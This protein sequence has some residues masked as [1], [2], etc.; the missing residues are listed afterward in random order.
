ML[1]YTLHL[2]G[3]G[4]K[5]YIDYILKRAK[6]PIDLDIIYERYELLKKKEDG[7]FVMT[8]LERKDIKNLVEEEVS[9]LDYYETNDHRYTLLGKSNYRKGRLQINK[10]GEGILHSST[11][12]TDKDGNLVIRNE[13]FTISSADCNGAID[14]DL[15]LIEISHA[16][17]KP[18]VERILER[19]IGNVFGEITRLG[20]H[21]FLT[22]IDPKQKNLTIALEG[23]Y[24]EGTLVLASLEEKSYH[25]YVGKVL[26]EFR[27]KDDP[28]A[29]SLT[30]AVK[31]GMPIGFSEESMRQLEEIPTIVSLKDKEGRYD[32]TNWDIFTIDGVDTKD[33]DDAISFTNVSLPDGHSL[34]GVHIADTPHYVPTN[35]P[36][37]KDAFRKGTSY[38]FGGSVNPQYPR[39]I[40]NGICSL[41]D[42]VERL[43][44]SILMEYDE[45]GNIVRRSLV[46]GV[47]RS[48]I[49]MNY[50]KVN[51]ILKDGVVDSEYA[52]YEKTLLQ[53]AKLAA[54][55]RKKRK[56]MGAISFSRGEPYFHYDDKGDAYDIVFKKQDLSEHLIEEFMLA[57]NHN[58]GAIME[59]AGLPTVYRVHG[60]PNR[61]KLADLLR[62]LDCMN[63]PFDYSAEEICQNKAYMQALSKHISEKGGMLQNML[64]TRLICCMAHAAYCSEN[65]GH[66]GTGF[67]VYVHFTSPI[68]RLADDT[69]SRVLDECYFEKDE[70][71]KNKAIRKWKS[72]VEI[73]SVQASKMERISEEVEKNVFLRDSAIFFSNHLEEEFEGTVIS[74]SKSGL[75]I[76]LDNLLEGRIPTYSLPGNYVYNPKTFTLLSLDDFDSY[77]MG[78]RLKVRVKSTDF[79][80]KTVH[81]SVLGK[82]YEN[83]IEDYTDSNEVLKN[84]KIVKRNNR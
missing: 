44:K 82:I 16:G 30:E 21:Y 13:M 51:A 7:N 75:T 70:E 52:P 46:R 56:N 76:Q 33:K 79:E 61:E 15:V 20:N 60:T 49:G 77:Y 10:L 31:S 73:Y 55:L 17:I 57:A 18:R 83:R 71:K 42:N 45:K 63:I 34:L 36:L 40:S 53:M 59:E 47:I 72:M 28:H 1:G 27:H 19:N 66:Y 43:T 41:S 26:Q 8:S 50:D 78:D 24:I 37:H 25:F 48:G 65:T 4:L 84:K 9:K 54:I 39:K 64:N 58:V 68:R 6:K 2:G 12:S 11:I 23:D 80:N 38:Y 3:Y 5:E 74:V 67:D 22:P 35:S 29:G 81:F 14:G 32:F 69:I 62:F